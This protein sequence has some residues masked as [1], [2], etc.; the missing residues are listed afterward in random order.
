MTFFFFTIKYHFVTHSKSLNLFIFRKI[1]G[2]RFYSKQYEQIYGPINTTTEYRSPRD[3]HGHGT[4]TAST[5]GGRRVS[6]V[7]ALGG[8]ANGTVSGGAPL[9][10]LAIYKVC[11]KLPAASSEAAVCPEADILSAFDD[12]IGDGVDIISVS[13]GGNTSKPYAQDGIAIGALSALK[14]NIVVVC[15]AGNSGP[16][17]Y[18]VTNVAPWIITVG[19]SS[20][21]RIFPASVL[22]GNGVT[23]EVINKSIIL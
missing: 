2:A 14:Q 15:S 11:W 23:H 3:G 18:S 17:P 9:V 21:D 10:R 8:F 5:I 4:H 1:I 20:I 6:N 12:A 13:I 19:A 7:S 22:L 16:T